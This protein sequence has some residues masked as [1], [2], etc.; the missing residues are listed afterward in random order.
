MGRVNLIQIAIH[1]KSCKRN[2]A[3]SS[4]L[5]L[6][7]CHVQT[8]ASLDLRSWPVQTCPAVATWCMFALVPTSG[9]RSFPAR[10]V[11]AICRRATA[12]WSHNARQWMCRIFPAPRLEHNPLHA[13][14]SVTSS[15]LTSSDKSDMRLFN[16]SVR[17]AHRTAP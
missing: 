3:M 14:L 4:S 9:A 11:I 7:T 17:Q 12:C 1:S 16:P 10:R 15:A 5:H 8:L 6:P 13:E 2:V